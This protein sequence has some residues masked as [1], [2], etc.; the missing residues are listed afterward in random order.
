VQ[1]LASPKGP[2]KFQ[3]NS[4]HPTIG[5]KLPNVIQNSLAS[6]SPSLLF[7]LASL[8]L[9]QGSLKRTLPYSQALMLAVKVIASKDT[10][11]LAI[12]LNSSKAC[13]EL[14]D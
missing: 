9:L 10:A 7:S 13:S 5:P 2:E 14:Q 12:T 6:G 3:R 8:E 11:V 4:R 1:S